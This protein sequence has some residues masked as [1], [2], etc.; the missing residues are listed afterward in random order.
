MVMQKLTERYVEEGLI[1]F[2]LHVCK[3]MMTHIDDEQKKVR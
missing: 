2:M 1:Y 3:E